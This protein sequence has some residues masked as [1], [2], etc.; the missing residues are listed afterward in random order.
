VPRW[1]RMAGLL[2]STAATIFV[3]FVTVSNEEI[4]V[5]S[6]LPV[7]AVPWLMF[8]LMGVRPRVAIVGDQIVVRNPF[9]S[10]RV[11]RSDLVRAEPGYFGM[12]L[13]VRNR[14]LP[15]LAWAVQKPNVSAMG[16]V[17]CRA[18]FV[19]ESIN[20]WTLQGSPTGLGLV[21]PAQPDGPGK[22][23]KK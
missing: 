6:A 7:I 4:S 8:L 21:L 15:I 10:R 3:V 18:D 14:K 23:N 5:V 22:R 11:P 9:T 16:S 17:S 1:A 20:A 13:R 19:A 2:C 12:L